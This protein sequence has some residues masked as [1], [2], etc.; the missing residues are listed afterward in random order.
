MWRKRTSHDLTCQHTFCLQCLKKCIETRERQDEIDCPV[1]S[2][3]CLLTNG[4]V[5]D[6][7]ASY[8]FTQL[9]DANTRCL[10]EKRKETVAEMKPHTECSYQ[11]ETTAEEKNMLCSSKECGHAA[12]AFCT[13]CKYICAECEHDHNTVRS[14]KTHV[15]MTVSEAAI[16]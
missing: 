7:P 1:C 9:K 13:S 3:V 2:K 5:E 16:I 8:L 12:N 10:T 14:L 6:L 4:N 15:I 11:E